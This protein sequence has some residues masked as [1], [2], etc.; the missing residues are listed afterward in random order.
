MTSTP[1]DALLLIAP[2]CAHCPQVLQALSDLLK[3]GALGRLEVVNVMAHPEA[4]EEVG[5]RSVPWTRIG[6]F[7]L[8]GSQ[9]RGELEKWLALAAEGSGMGE[10]LVHLL[11]TQRLARVEETIRRTPALL[12][13]LLPAMASLDTPMAVRIGIGAVMESFAGSDTLADIVPDLGALTRSEHPQVRADACHYLALSERPEAAEF[14]R[15]L[16]DDG[17]QEV[18]DIAMESLPLVDHTKTD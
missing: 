15:P 7:E 10:Y 18:R 14:I 11:E 5:T 17:D 16:L 3:Q 9:T 12:R 8:E 2:G 13:D 1:P 6:P 4:A